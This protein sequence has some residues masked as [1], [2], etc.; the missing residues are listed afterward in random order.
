MRK[1][2]YKQTENRRFNNW[3]HSNPLWILEGAGQ[4][5]YGQNRA[6]YIYLCPDDYF[7]VLLNYLH[8]FQMF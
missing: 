5:V 3:V 4:F 1:F 2:A 8:G 7:D 6:K